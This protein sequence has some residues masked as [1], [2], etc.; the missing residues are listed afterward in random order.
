MLTVDKSEVVSKTENELLDIGYDLVFDD[1]F[2]PVLLAFSHILQI[3]HFE[4]ILILERQCRFYGI[5]GFGQHLKEVARQRAA[6]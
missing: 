4:H 6:I 5:S 2:V 1:L 3:N